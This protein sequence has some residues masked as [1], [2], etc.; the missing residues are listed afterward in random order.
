MRSFS[1][2]RKVNSALTKSAGLCQAECLRVKEQGKSTED[3]VGHLYITFSVLVFLAEQFARAHREVVEINDPHA[4]V[5]EAA[6]SRLFVAQQRH[7]VVH[8]IGENLRIEPVDGMIGPLEYLEES[9]VR[10]DEQAGDIIGHI[11]ERALFGEPAQDLIIDD[12]PR[13]FTFVN[14]AA[15]THFLQSL[16]NVW[17]TGKW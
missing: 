7:I 5:V 14:Q 11:V 6:T 4:P 17:R 3:V 8:F 2:R 16:G 12:V 9:F 15:K 1:V 13:R 10:E